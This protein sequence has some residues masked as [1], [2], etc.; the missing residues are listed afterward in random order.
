MTS[1]PDHLGV[2]PTP[3]LAD[4]ADT[5]ETAWQVIRE[6]LRRRINADAHPSRLINQIALAD[7]RCRA[8]TRAL[9]R[10]LGHSPK[11]LTVIRTE[12]RNAFEIDPDS[13][14]FTVPKLP[15]SPSVPE[16]VDSLTDRALLLLVLPSVP[17][18]VN[19]FTGLSVK[20]EPNRRLPYTPLDVLERVIALRLF[21]RLAR[22]HTDYWATL[23]QGGWL[24]RRERWVELHAQLFADRA[25]IA[26]QLDELSS[27]GMAMVQ[28]VIDAPTAEARQR[29]GGSW[30]CVRVGQMMWPG[31]PAVAI[32]GALHFFREGNPD[33]APHV[34]YLP[35]VARNFYEYPSFVA[36]QCGVLELNR[37][38][39]H[40]LWL[41]LPLSRRNALCQPADL[42]P[43]SSVLRGLTVTG[44]ALA[45]SAQALLSEQWGNELACAVMIN[46]DH[47]FSTQ[48]P[49][50]PPLT[51]GPFLAHVESTRK[52]LV[53]SARLGVLGNQMLTW[54]QQ[55]RRAEI[56]FA[57]T[58]SGL[59]L[60][61]AE[62]QIKRY[63][64]ALVALLDPQDPSAE[65]PAYQQLM[66]L[67]SHLKVQAQA[68]KTL[69]Q[70]A[71][72]RL[73][74]VAFWTERPGGAGT[75]R[76]GTLF[77]TAQTEA[78]RCEVQLQHRLKL[79]STAHRD[80][81]IEVLEQPLAAKR[82]GSQTQVLSIAVGSD[83]DAFYPLH[84]V[85]V[86]TTAAAVR[87]PT[88]QHPVVLYAFGAEGGVLGFSGLEALTRS[89]KASLS[90]RDDSVLWGGVERDKRNDLRAHALRDSLSVR[91]VPI[92][93]KPALAALQKMLGSFDRLY[94]STED[95]TRLFSEVKDAELSRALLLV[96]LKEQ[97]KVPANSALAHALANIE[98]LLK[99]ASE[100][101]K[102]PTWLAGAT[103]TQRRHF[104]R[105]QRRYLSG[106][107]AYQARLEQH[108][109]GLETF[110][111]CAL[112]AR[113]SEDAISPPL[114]I[115]QPFIDMPDDVHGS[116]C[117]GTSACPVGDRNII[118]TPSATR[119]TFSLLQLV[120]HNLDP[121]AP[122]TR[123]R[124]SRARFL[125]PER[126]PPLGADYLIR[127][128]SS[129][130][131]G[132]QY[133]ALIKQTF[134]P[135]LGIDDTL[136]QGRIPALLNRAL[137]AG[138]AH[139]LRCA[140]H[141]GLTAPAQRVFSTAMAARTAQDLLKNQHELQLYV[142]HLVGHTMQHDRYIAGIV[143]VHDKRSGR[144]VS[145]WPQATTPA[146]ILTEYS[147]LQQAHDALNRIGALPDNAKALARQVAPGWAFEAITHHPGRVDRLDQALNSLELSPTAFMLK[148]VWH[149]REFIR[150]FSVKHLEPT[151]LADEIEKQTL[152]QLASD[153]QHGLALVA[154]S[155][156][157]AQ[158][159]LYHACVLELQRRTQAASHSGKAL[160]AYRARRLGEQ[161]D[162]TQRRLVAFFNPLVG[163]FNDFYELLLAARRY[164]RF[165]DPH[166]A[167]DVGFMSAFLAIDVL[168]NFIP[169]PKPAGGSATRMTRP[170]LRPAL[171]RIH[172]LRMT[173]H[174]I[175]RSAPS[176]VPQLQ[177]I[178][179]F[180]TKGIPQGAVALKGV[181]ENAVQV[182][183]G[184]AFVADDTHHYPLYR[185]GD[186]QVF[187]LKNTQ[188]P[189]QDEL[190]LN[191]HQPREWLLGADRPQP[192]A[193]T[194]SAL[195][196]PWHAPVSAA[197]DWRPPIVRSATES[198]IL[199]SSATA[200]HWVSWRMD[201]E[202]NPQLSSPA[203]GVFHIPRDAREFAYNV[204][205]VAPPNTQLTDPLSVY[206][207]LLP[208]GGQAPLNRI[209]FIHRNE[210]LVSLA[211]VDIERWTSTALAEQPLPVSRT[212]AGRWQVHAP[213][214]DRPLPMYVAQAF[215][216]MTSK[217]R[218]F[219]V[220]RILEL[221]GPERPA[222]ASHLLNMRATLDDWLPAAP[223]RA[224]QTDDLL[225][226]LRS[227]ETRT[228]YLHV[229][230]EGAAPGFT[231]VDFTPPVPLESRLQRGG[232]SVAR[233]RQAVQR[234]AVKSVLEQQGFT[235]RVLEGVRYAR[236]TEEL[237]AIHPTA[238]NRLY[239]VAYQWVEKGGIYMGTRFKHRWFN[240]LRPG[241]TS[242]RLS[243]EVSSALHEQRLVRIMAGIQWPD[244]KDKAPSVY[245]IKLNPRVE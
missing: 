19:Q 124:L 132:G 94:Q 27:R 137:H 175:S 159:L 26:R 146:L 10:L 106:A 196:N 198:R 121:L 179:P 210:Q 232:R 228:D 184:E 112:N 191:I 205:R 145:Y 79:L 241:A 32:P 82:L 165:G 95:I 117:G 63:E 30:A 185:R 239:Y 154:T 5:A 115:D 6:Q 227:S 28:A 134:Y 87:V 108:L 197:P 93:G 15:A 49:R 142:V 18:N 8:S 65:T 156:F 40:D 24:T 125:Q 91:Y 230:Y 155:H 216:T 136:S 163:M 52:R 85:W 23:V 166:D 225:R 89:V 92:N 130:D 58:A 169:G 226:M 77:M 231:R 157:N 192:V 12:L 70:G 238:P 243:A 127:M 201:I 218:E 244:W 182:K 99:T 90:S 45:L 143:L 200:T 206:Y 97:L 126:K 131:I 66:A 207:R 102:L 167:V 129:L 153:P 193:G 39:F 224:G 50:P 96:E 164:H 181:G 123:W 3:D 57:S 140:T 233:D 33:D 84:N 103:R 55:R 194:R 59:P 220:A 83:P 42:S 139:H 104:K 245:F 51:A 13:L 62:Q 240:A 78:L 21:D 86:V 189:G 88:R 202:V 186:E 67:L 81:I 118:L 217:S 219:T 170:G 172:R 162:A 235:L 47:V 29:A 64:K 71:Q 44:D 101:K 236:A 209:V 16:H 168:A 56:I 237:V 73:L 75:P 180:R 211:R 41:C 177:A 54:D 1:S 74:E 61:T 128:V 100:A 36:L 212:S 190:I 7:W 223:A 161:S 208:E 37:S 72:Q 53:G 138:F 120:L 187:R 113:L 119:T 122:W 199:H 22:A 152:E 204:L 151:A 188:A 158:A 68:L 46:H 109:P 110:A 222:T 144:C 9:T 160:D 80:L 76:R 178:A 135:R 133:D 215:P 11:I 17:I 38:L 31:T 4:T 107:F 221:S 43:A 213:L 214:F 147:S 69:T 174:E 234:A 173:T 105:S 111:R 114:D 35:G 20:G 148:G 2:I 116:Y 176:T 229:G 98:L 195:L 150:S 60:R 25:F 242:V 183:N 14:L 34:I 141:A 149:G 171:G 48:R 203:P